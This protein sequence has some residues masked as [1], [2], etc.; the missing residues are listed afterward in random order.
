[1]DGE[2]GYVLIKLLVFLLLRTIE[3]LNIW[4]NTYPSSPF[5]YRAIEQLNVW[6]YAY[7]SSPPPY[8]AIEKLNIWWICIDPHVE[9][10]Y[11]SIGGGE[12]R[13]V[14]TQTLSFSIA[15]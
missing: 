6:V 14:L 11:C 13:Y 9:F 8:R 1:V 3:K 7:Q 4:V 12:L 15:W 2:L 5:P 10:F